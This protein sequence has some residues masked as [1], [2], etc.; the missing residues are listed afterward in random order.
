[1]GVDIHGLAADEADQRQP[2]LLGEFRRPASWAPRLQRAPECPPAHAF[3]VSSKDARPDTV[4]IIWRSG[5]SC[6][7]MAQ[8]MTLSTALCRPTSSRTHDH[9]RS[10]ARAALPHAARRYGRTPAAAVAAA[11]V[12]RESARPAYLDPAFIAYGDSRKTSSMRGG[13]ADPARAG[14]EDVAPRGRCWRGGSDGARVTSST[15]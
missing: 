6:C 9:L 15:L 1:M 14:R 2:G 13:A 8:P 10:R 11:S 12:P 7:W 4:K 5:S 3:W